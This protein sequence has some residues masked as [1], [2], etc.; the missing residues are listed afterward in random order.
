MNQ[1]KY[2]SLV[3]RILKLQKLVEQGE[4][5]EAANARAAIETIVNRYGLSLDEILQDEGKKNYYWTLK[6]AREK[7]LWRQCLGTVLNTWNPRIGEKGNMVV[8]ELT[9]LQYAE[10]KD[11][12][13]FH[14]S[15]MEH[16]YKEMIS[17]F[18]SAYFGKHNIFPVDG[19]E[20]HTD[21]KMDRAKLLRI[22]HMQQAM[23]NK[24]YRKSIT[25]GE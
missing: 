25:A 19:V 3:S 17:T 24:S 22:I 12:F 4:A 10:F 8:A 13:D 18:E 9:K 23:E 16:E 2:E 7:H 15:N 14:R 6:T 1:E 5:G 20:E 11:M 21:N